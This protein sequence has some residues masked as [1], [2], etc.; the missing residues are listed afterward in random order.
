MLD[1]VA[2][3]F[4]LA[5]KLKL[6]VSENIVTAP[7]IVLSTYN[8]IVLTSAN[9]FLT[10]SARYSNHLNFSGSDSHVLEL[11]YESTQAQ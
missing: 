6:L 3:Y 11:Q 5:I 2:V 7:I 8:V 9:P 1:Q 10:F 4:H